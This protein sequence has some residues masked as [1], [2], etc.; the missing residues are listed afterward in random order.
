M[1]DGARRQPLRVALFSLEP[2][3]EVWR[4]NQHLA[5]RIAGTVDVESVVFVTPPRGGLALR[6]RRH[7]PMPGVEVVEP[8][9][10]EP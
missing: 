5:S 1:T 3:D 6:A 4:R 7:H 9:Y 2:W 10:I 8:P